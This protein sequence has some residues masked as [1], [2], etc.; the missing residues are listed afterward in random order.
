MKDHRTPLVMGNWKMHGGLLANAGLL[1]ALLSGFRPDTG[2]EMA[3]CVPYP[4]LAQVQVKLANSHITWGA[5]DTSAHSAGAH[6]GEVSAG[7]LAEFGVSW[8]LCG[9]SERRAMHAES[10]DLVAAKAAAALAAGLTP[11]VCLG[12][13]LEDRKTGCEL[14][15]I[16]AQLQPILDL[17]EASLSA[18]LV[19]YEP[20]WAIGTGHT[21]TPQ[22]AQD[23]HAHIRA[24][25]Q[26]HGAGQVRILYGGSVKPDNAAG[27]FAGQDIDGALVGGASLVAQD[28]LNIAA[29]AARSCPEH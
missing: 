8:V 26:Q 1:D 11:V 27:L 7:M 20:V 23:M 3:V 6:T 28:F 25:L 19:A 13:T 4:Y 2:V 9:H 15:V 29:A 17:G 22:Q 21:A 10:N 16:D 5:Q 14:S 12:E 24:V 18:L